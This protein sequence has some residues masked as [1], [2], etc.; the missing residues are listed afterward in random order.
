[1]SA[2]RTA[3][4]VGSTSWGTVLAVMLARNGL[5]VRLCA[6]DE[7]DAAA[8][9]RNGEN[10]RLQPGLRFPPSLTVTHE[11]EVALKGVDLLVVAVPSSTLRDNLRALHPHLDPDTLVLSALSK[12]WSATQGRGCHRS[13][14][15][16]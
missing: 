11:R 16:S 1:M 10:A 5:A 7:A 9:R 15:R 14:R 6:Y 2:V 3:A 8:L 13:S 12:G 4:V